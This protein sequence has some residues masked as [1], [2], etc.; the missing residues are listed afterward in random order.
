MYYT[1]F[2]TPGHL[3]TRTKRR[4]IIL[5]PPNARRL[6]FNLVFSSYAK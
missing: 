3:T 6:G 2:P 4:V 5:G 1:I